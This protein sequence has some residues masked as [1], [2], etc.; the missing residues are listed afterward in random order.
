MV[1]AQNWLDENYP[2]GACIQYDF[3]F[4][5][6]K[7]KRSEVSKI[8][9]NEPSLEGELDLK[10]FTYWF[11]R[12]GVE[13][14]IS[15]LVDASKI[16]FINQGEDVKIIKLVKAQQWLDQNY[17]QLGVC[18]KDSWENNKGKTRAEITKLSIRWQNLEGELDLSDFINC[19]ELDCYYNKLTSLNISNCSQ[20]EKIEC[21]HNKLTNLDLSN[22]SQLSKIKCS[23]NQLA[24]YWQDIHPCFDYSGKSS[25]KNWEKHGFT[26]KQTKQWI[27]LG[28]EPKNYNFISWLRDQQ[29]V[30]WEWANN[31]PVEFAYLQ[32]RYHFYGLCQHCQQ[33]NTSKDWCQPCKSKHYQE[34]FSNWTSGN[35]E[36]DKLIQQHQLAA[37][38][39]AKT[40]KWIP[41]ENFRNIEKIGE[42]GFSK[43]YKAEWIEGTIG[44]HDFI[45][46]K[47]ETGGNFMRVEVTGE[48]GRAFLKTAVG[49]D[50]DF[51]R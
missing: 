26:K 39:E 38:K 14:Y 42:G 8:Y 48:A 4:R 20:L 16:T 35:P 46:R 36:I 18:Q 27:K 51:Q 7:V 21:S 43:V 23:Y 15:F 41:Y 17:P 30:D 3:Y 44:Y 19:R 13:V 2:E 6:Q 31:K 37:T 24:E 47:K 40:L 50:V 10:D 33:I 28:V 11:G 9:L 45:E 32:E 1:N 29:Q 34:N 22:C 25:K 5:K 12:I 49:V